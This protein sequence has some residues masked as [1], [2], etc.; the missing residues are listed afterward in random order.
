MEGAAPRGW[1]E[2]GR[3]EHPGH[4]PRGGGR[5]CGTGAEEGVALARGGDGRQLIDRLGDEGG[6]GGE[7]AAVAVGHLRRWVGR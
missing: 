4:T 2:R 7:A 5:A 6:D 1:R 3:G